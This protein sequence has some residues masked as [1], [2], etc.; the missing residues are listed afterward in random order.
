MARTARRV[1]SRF[2]EPLRHQANCTFLAL[3]SPQ[4]LEA[5]RPM[6]CWSC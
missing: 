4:L 5:P 3:K 6:H 1:V 2:G